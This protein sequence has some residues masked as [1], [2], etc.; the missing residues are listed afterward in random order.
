MGFVL[1]PAALGA[2]FTGVSSLNEVARGQS[3]IASRKVS[4]VGVLCLGILGF[5]AG[6]AGCLALRATGG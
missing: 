5:F 4:Y 6:I 1:W 3:S 2:I